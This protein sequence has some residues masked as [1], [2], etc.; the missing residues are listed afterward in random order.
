[1][2][3]IDDLRT[4]RESAAARLKEVLAAPKPSYSID[5]QQVSWTQY[6]E[7]L[8]RMV[9]QLTQDIADAEAAEDPYE[10]HT[11]GFN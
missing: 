2:S 6:T 7:M 4:A 10:I 9:A 11:R 8:R 5:G 3:Y 1:M